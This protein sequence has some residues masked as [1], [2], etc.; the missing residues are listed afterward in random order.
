[1]ARR[2]SSPTLIGRR[3][4]LHQL[5]AAFER[6]A[7]GRPGVA[8]VAG[9]AGVG[10]TRLVAELAAWA[11]QQDHQ[12][13]IGACVSLSADVAP[14]AAVV[15][16]LRPL[17]R[18]LSPADLE[19][20]LG[21]GS[22]ELASVLPW[23]GSGSQ[24]AHATGISEDTATAR[25]LE[26][27]LGLLGRLA[28]RTP[29][30]LFI[31]DAHWA[32]RSTLDL[33]A[34]LSRN[35]RSER[36]L[37][38]VTY[39]T[40]EVGA[41]GDLL[42]LIAE[43]GRNERT[44]RI[45]LRSLNRA[46]VAEQL[47][48]ILGTPASSRLTD[49]VFSRSQG[50]AFF[51]EE[52]LAAGST[53]DAMPQTLRDVLTSRLASL[54]P[55]ARELVRVASAAGRRFSEAL[56]RRI[57]SGDDEVAFHPALREAVE[58][59][60][61]VRERV[62]TGERLAF[63][64]A[65]MREI[66][67]DDLLP[68]E[69]RQLHAACATAIEGE[70]AAGTDPI[71]ASELAYHWQAA[72]EPERALRASIAA[73]NAAEAASA[74]NEAAMQFERALALLDR[75]PG[76]PA[77]LP[78]DRVDL[79]EH[80]AT[81][82]ESDPARAVQ[83]IQAALG[84]VSAESDPERTGTLQ[85]ALGRHL[86]ASGDALGALAACREAVRLVPENP[87][88]VARARVEA[89]LGQ[90]MMILGYAESA[91]P[92]ASVAVE[93]AQ[94]T[95][96]RAIESH[97]LNT[98]GILTAHL[99]DLE[100]G[101]A[102][103]WR[104]LE[105][106]EEISSIDDIGRAYANITDVL[107]FAAGR[108]DE[109]AEIGI[110]A[111]GLPETPRFVGVA[112]ALQYSDIIFALYLAGRWDEAATAIEQAHLQPTSGVGE[113]GLGVREAQLAVGR[114]MF[115][116]AAQRL[117]VLRQQLADT[118]DMQWVAP[119]VEANA[120]LAIWR[121]EPGAA[122]RA[123][124][125]GMPR[126]HLDFGANI[127]RIGPILALGVRAAADAIERSGRRRSAA[128]ERARQQAADHLAVARSFHDQIATKWPS[129]AWLSHAYRSLV[130]AEAT[131]VAGS[132]DPEAWALAATRFEELPQPYTRAYARYREGE[133]LLAA[134]HG[135]A[136]AR[137]A[138]REAHAI[139][140][141]LGA[142]PLRAAVESVARRG[143][144]EVDAADALLRPPADQH[145][146]TPRELEILGLLAAGLTNRQIGDRLFITEKTAGHHVSNVLAKLG[147]SGRAEAA[148]EAV[149]LGIAAPTG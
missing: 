106:A 32:D 113:I 20:V 79:L 86:W 140:T 126:V 24:R 14:Y 120:E 94:A 87:P 88:S 81:N 28:E 95:G 21:P 29:V 39:R 83:H 59:Q 57:A 41:R 137:S 40:D 31:E 12:V 129:H 149:R 37:L 115:D 77:D 64:H 22:D 15:D 30:L 96:Q 131:R 56:L 54:S 53:A 125:E 127:T 11:R 18:D 68:G 26:H 103:L 5:R 141:A 61:L 123:V 43:L 102:K 82:L 143:R 7:A 105:I 117:A 121:G 110:R 13:L 111:I 35:L 50:N 42:P 114:G 72:D 45:E 55:E 6:A 46:E 47:G 2:L 58:H 109:S 66:L 128:A 138:L 135:A 34:F 73:A 71:L 98:L 99:G 132:S 78:M 1:M 16:A 10:K 4:E 27:V 23:L 108:Y 17:N 8:L 147:V 60:I 36:V 75:L 69:R 19:T 70:L 33:L 49:A 74:Q 118:N 51:T 67:Y 9:E 107:I 145:G 63:R 101:L 144:I 124:A 65:L 112:A 136:R 3:D 91:V 139:T 142:A 148:A 38:G 25:V 62:E 146:L 134:R 116:S 80:A 130:E 85:A 48:A 92:H 44:E 97:A 104:S 89:G 93:I 76:L 52:L 90:I 84:L 100:G 122:L 133:A 119:F